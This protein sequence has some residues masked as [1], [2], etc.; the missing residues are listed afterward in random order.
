MLQQIVN[1]GSCRRDVLYKELVYRHP[2]GQMILYDLDMPIIAK[3]HPLTMQGLEKWV[4][5]ND[6]NIGI[7]RR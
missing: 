2:L 7:G 5:V 4:G 6:D 3:Y 1:F